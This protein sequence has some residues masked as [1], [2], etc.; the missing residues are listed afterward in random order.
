MVQQGVWRGCARD[1]AAG[2]AR[3][4]A[5]GASR[6]SSLVKHVH[7]QAACPFAERRQLACQ[8]RCGPLPLL[9]R[10][11]LPVCMLGPAW[12]RGAGARCGPTPHASSAGAAAIIQCQICSLLQQCHHLPVCSIQGC[13]ASQQLR[14][15]CVRR[16]AAAAIDVSICSC[17]GRNA[18]LHDMHLLAAI[19]RCCM[20][21]WQAS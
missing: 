19:G 5:A 9:A 13:L 20:M 6:A 15:S 17:Q 4:A 7:S 14:W 1:T 16:P 10:W 18:G 21:A 12:W 8:W 11:C 3:C 2:S